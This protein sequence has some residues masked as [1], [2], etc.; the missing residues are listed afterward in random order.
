MYARES[1]FLGQR[2]SIFQLWEKAEDKKAGGLRPPV[3]GVGAKRQAFRGHPKASL[4]VFRPTP[5]TG[6]SPP[7]LSSA[8]P[9]S[10]KIEQR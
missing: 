8:F 3:G 4:P 7:A 2:Y 10:G 1:S 5:P 6:R 9:P